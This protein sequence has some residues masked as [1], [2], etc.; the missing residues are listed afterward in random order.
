MT[1]DLIETIWI[2]TLFRYLETNIVSAGNIQTRVYPAINH[3]TSKS[4]KIYIL[5]LAN[6]FWFPEPKSS[7]TLKIKNAAYFRTRDK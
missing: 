6:I 1:D 2:L 5:K 3:C 4:P 7:E